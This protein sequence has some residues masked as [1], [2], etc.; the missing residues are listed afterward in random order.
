MSRSPQLKRA[1]LAT[2]SQTRTPGRVACGPIWLLTRE[3]GAGVSPLFPSTARTVFRVRAIRDMSENTEMSEYLTDREPT[4]A[5]PEEPRAFGAIFGLRKLPARYTLILSCCAIA[6]LATFAAPSGSAAASKWTLRQL[7]PTTRTSEGETHEDYPAL[8]GVSCPSE[9]LCVA[10]GGYIDTPTLAFSQ[11]PTGSLAQWHVV[12]LPYPIG[13]GKTC[14][15]G[16]PGCHEPDGGFNAV[17]CASQ[18]LCVAVSGDGFL[19]ASTEPT[20]GADAWSPTVIGEGKLSLNAVSCPSSSL[21]VAVA[22]G[23]NASNGKVL[24]STSPTSGSWQ[25]TQ[26]SSSLNFHGVSCATPSFCL[27]V[28]GEGQI[29]ASTDPTGGASAWRETG[30]PGGSGDQGVDC[31][32]TALCAVGD[33]GGNI[34]TST[35]PAA[36]SATWSEVNGGS[37]MRITGVSCPTANRCV[38]VD[39][40]GDL[41]SSSDPTGGTG[42]W[43]LENLVPFKEFL[44]PENGLFA[45]S[46]PSV[47]LC[48]LVGIDGRIFTS[49]EPFSAPAAPPA[50]RPARPRTVLLLESHPLQTRH[51]RVRARFRFYS[52]TL[53]RGFECKR[54]RGPYRHCHS[55]LRYWVAS[56]RRHVLRVRA[57]GPTGLRGPATID[58][59]RVEHVRVSPCVRKRRASRSH[60]GLS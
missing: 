59:F 51:R 54:D 35:D 24:T 36:S 21:C 34:L 6:V 31:V 1:G 40:N 41:L 48:A 14:V 42:S 18:K 44:F 19:Y 12:T 29:V 23:P 37:S 52:H 4:A 53:V 7:P 32:G 57:I 9:S 5:S 27:A 43:H 45:A 58:R 15:A 20:A 3:R 50:E 10:A 13:P 17:S 47:S 22:G 28:T 2:N 16:E 46:C 33:A 25:M 60:L 55:P 26:L 38:A 8:K 49:T 39:D 30:A 11:A 56:G